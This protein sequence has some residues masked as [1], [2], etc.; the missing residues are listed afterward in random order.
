V[1]QHSNGIPI[2]DFIGEK[3]DCVLKKFYNYLLEFK[4]TGAIPDVREKLAK[5]F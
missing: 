1:I 4:N 2:K 3:D 5:D